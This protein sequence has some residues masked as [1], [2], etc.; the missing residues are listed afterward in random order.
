ME[1]ATGDRETQRES[2]GIR[3]IEETRNVRNKKLHIPGDEE[4][5]ADNS[6]GIEAGE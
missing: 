1:T 2:R 4:K 5:R 3:L 6:D